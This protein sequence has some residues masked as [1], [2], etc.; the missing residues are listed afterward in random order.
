VLYFASLL[1]YFFLKTF[2]RVN[3]VFTVTHVRQIYERNQSRTRS[4]WLIGPA[5]H[6]LLWTKSADH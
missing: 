6:H 3:F 5:R 2:L 4:F 1:Y